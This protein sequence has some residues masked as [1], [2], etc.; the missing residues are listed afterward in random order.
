AAAQPGALEPR[1]AGTGPL[2]PDT[3]GGVGEG[4]DGGQGGA[5]SAAPARPGG[6]EP[7]EDTARQ[8]DAAAGQQAL[9]EALAENDP[10]EQGDKER[11]RVHDHGRRSR[12]H[13]AL[14]R[15]EGEAVPAE[16]ENPEDPA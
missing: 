5:G 10:G 4:R 6:S 7:D 3:R 12:V 16:K 14:R 8:R 13:L 1:R 11:A 15:V 2:R 9:R